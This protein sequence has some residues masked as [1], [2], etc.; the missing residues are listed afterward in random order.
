MLDEGSSESPWTST[1]RPAI[2][3]VWEEMGGSEGECVL[4]RGFGVAVIIP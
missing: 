2:V 1:R 4:L 3:K